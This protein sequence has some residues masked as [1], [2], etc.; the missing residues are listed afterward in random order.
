LAKDRLTKEN[1]MT[2]NI[3]FDI[4]IVRTII[5]K[6]GLPSLGSASIREI[7][8]LVNEVKPAGFYTVDFNGT[9]YSSGVYFY[10][11]ESAGFIKIKK[12]V[13]VK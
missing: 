6:N 1:D 2:H 8:K 4:S 13:L 12:M 7:V 3:P 11:L 5:E 10:K 9:K